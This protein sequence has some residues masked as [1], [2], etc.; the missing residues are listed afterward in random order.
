[1]HLLNIDIWMWMQAIAPKATASA[2]RWMI[3]K[4]FQQPGHWL[5]LVGD[6][7]IPPPIGDTLRSLIRQPYEWGMHMVSTVPVG[8]LAHWLAESAS[9]NAE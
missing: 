6:V 7:Y 2:F 4:L 9:I 1:M 8:E 5:A 3:W